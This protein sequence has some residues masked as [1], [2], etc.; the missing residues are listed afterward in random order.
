MNPFKYKILH[1]KVFWQVASFGHLSSVISLK[2]AYLCVVSYW[3]KWNILNIKKNETV[4]K[5][6]Q[7]AYKFK[8]QG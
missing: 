4:I 8:F 3:K 7:T 1:K 5:N 2:E 6:C